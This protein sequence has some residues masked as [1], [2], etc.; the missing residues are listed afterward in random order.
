MSK[1]GLRMV[2]LRHTLP[3][4]KYLLTVLTV[5]KGE[6]PIRKKGGVK[7]LLRVGSDGSTAGSF[8]SAEMEEGPE[9]SP[10]ERALKGE[11]GPAAN[12]NGNR[13]GNRKQGVGFGGRYLTAGRGKR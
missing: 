12:G 11:N 2:D 8:Q 13:N 4:L 10:A 6:L 1:Q 9:S 5:G 7:G 3:N